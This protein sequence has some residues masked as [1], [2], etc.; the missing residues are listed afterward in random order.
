MISI[1]LI[2]S[3]FLMIYGSFNMKHIIRTEYNVQT[4]IC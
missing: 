2:L 3:A 1:P 4:K